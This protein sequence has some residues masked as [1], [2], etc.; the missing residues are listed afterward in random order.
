MSWYC[1]QTHARAEDKAR[2]NLEAQGYEA[3]L[4]LVLKRLSHARRVHLGAR[5]LFPRYL[6]VEADV[7]TTQW[8]P[9]RSTFG[10]SNLVSFGE[11]PAV[12]PDWMISEL[13]QAENAEGLIAIG[14]RAQFEKGQQVEICGGAL[15]GQAAV[16]DCVADHERV[17][18][19]LNLLNRQMRVRMPAAVISVSA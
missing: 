2:F 3:Y 19:L 5:P 16:F 6:F 12:V 9:I 15:A 1:V 4:P 8:R 17:Y 7:E 11:T 10:V 13:K 14:R 18:V